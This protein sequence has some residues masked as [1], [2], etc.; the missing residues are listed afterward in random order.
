MDCNIQLPVPVQIDGKFPKRSV[1]QIQDPLCPAAVQDTKCFLFVVTAQIK[2]LI[3]G[4]IHFVPWPDGKPGRKFLIQ[5][6]Q[7]PLTRI[8]LP[9][10]LFPQPGLLT[11]EFI[12]IRQFHG[13]QLCG[14]T[15][16]CSPDIPA[17]AAVIMA[18][19]RN[20]R[21]LRI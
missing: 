21:I 3:E 19:Q 14:H 4:R 10:I 9:L 11:L 1:R 18:G 8:N 17:A 5:F 16:I 15:M 6:T 20:V 13:T 2:A 7:H 12:Y